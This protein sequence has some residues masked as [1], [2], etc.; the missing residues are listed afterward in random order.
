MKVNEEKKE[1]KKDGDLIHPVCPG[2]G[3]SLLCYDVKI[4]GEPSMKVIACPPE[5]EK[6]GRLL[7]LCTI[8]GD[9]HNTIDTMDEESKQSIKIG[10]ITGIRCIYCYDKLVIEEECE[11][12]APM[13]EMLEADEHGIVGTIRV[14]ARKGCHTHESHELSEGFKP[15]FKNAGFITSKNVKKFHKIN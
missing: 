12:G 4:D 11:C 7:R 9:F 14:C 6:N 5:E 3:A 1:L 8:W 13:F 10:T 2:C 15:E